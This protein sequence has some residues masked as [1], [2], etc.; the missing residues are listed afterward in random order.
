MKDWLGI[1]LM[2]FY[3]FVK[4]KISY[5]VKDKDLYKANLKLKLKPLNDRSIYLFINI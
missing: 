4:F 5:F 2:M 3:L 1:T